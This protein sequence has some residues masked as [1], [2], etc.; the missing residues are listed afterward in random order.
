MKTKI[1]NIIK[2]IL[3]FLPFIVVMVYSKFFALAFFD[4]E[5][6]YYIWNRE[7]CKTSHAENYRS[8]IIGDSIA[9]AAFIPEVLSEST[10][11][12]GLGGAS[13][14]EAYYIMSDWLTHN[15]APEDVFICFYDTNIERSTT[16]WVRTMYSHRFTPFQNLEIINNAARFGDNDIASSNRWFDFISYEL[17]LPN[18][19]ITSI[20][21]GKVYKRLAKNREALELI[22]LHR[23]RYIIATGTLPEI[24]PFEYTEFKVSGLFDHYYRQLIDLCLKNGCRV[25][26][27]KLPLPSDAVFT[28][29][30]I[31]TVNEYY[32]TLKKDYPGI[33]FEWFVEDYGH[34]CFCDPMHF[35]AHGA[36]KFNTEVLKER[37]PDVF[38]ND[39]TDRQKE[40]IIY[41]IK[42][43]EPSREDLL[44]W[45]ELG[46]LNVTEN[47]S[48]T[49]VT[50][51]DPV[52]RSTI[53][54]KDF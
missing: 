9:N 41:N 21:N 22:D 49:H 32:D 39:M 16:F 3:V 51:T 7:F 29:E 54:E 50:I 17:Y 1:I 13:P 31:K 33:D 24:P 23:G 6:P 46:G 34:D 19:Y 42:N 40:A 5:T 14:A 36:L 48:G 45:C 53:F 37:Y 52:S 47:N 15:K 44:K 38:D 25:H 35:N 26:L 30:Y 20:C 28:G 27:L 4:N 11:N 2:L 10:L 18:K 8:L 12:L 43:D